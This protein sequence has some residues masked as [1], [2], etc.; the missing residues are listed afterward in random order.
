MTLEERVLAIPGKD[1]FWKSH[2]KDTFLKTALLLWQRGFSDNEVID[3]LEKLWY[4]VSNE[5]G[6]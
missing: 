4:A 6:G 5:Y 2:T 1:G 3:I